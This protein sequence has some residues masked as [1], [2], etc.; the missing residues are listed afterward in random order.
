MQRFRDLIFADGH[1]GQRECAFRLLFY[2]FNFR[3][4]PVNC[5]NWI[6]R[7]LLAIQYVFNIRISL[8]H[9]HVPLS[10]HNTLY[11]DSDSDSSERVGIIQC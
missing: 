1:S 9:V 2:G 5:E 8:V 7:K 10:Q 6:P 11:Y 3:G 4:L